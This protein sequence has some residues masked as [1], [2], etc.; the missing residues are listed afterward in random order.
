M[1]FVDLYQRRVNRIKSEIERLKRD[2]LSY[3][4]RRVEKNNKIS[5]ATKALRTSRILSTISAKQREIDRYQRELCDIDKKIADYDKRI[6]LKEKELNTD[7]MRLLQ[8]QKNLE[9]KQDSERKKMVDSFNEQLENQKI[10]NQSLREELIKL[11]QSKE[12]I[13]I[14]FLAACP[15][16]VTQLK[17]DK[18]AREIHGS[19]QKALNRDSIN[20]Q[21]RWATRITDIL[22]SINEVRPTI[23][24]FSGHGCVDGSLVF[25]DNNDNSK[26][27][28]IEDFVKLIYTCSDDVRLVVLNNCYSSVTAKELVSSIESA[29]GMN[30][31]I[32]DESAVIFASQLYSGIGFGLN[33]EKAFNQAIVQMK[34]LGVGG[35]EIPELYVSDG[36]L[37]KD[38]ILVCDK[39]E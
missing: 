31:S 39:K 19:I 34:I 13:S 15:N 26:L 25:Q 14:L 29:I 18:E 9:R 37:A 20:F 30:D 23:I 7:E 17:L 32:G 10:V 12:K 16:D 3:Y 2:R 8:E 4:K 5:Q 1:S 22:Q 35:E 6:I 11:K 21:T 36:L 24:H 27:L 28:P 33:L 38:L